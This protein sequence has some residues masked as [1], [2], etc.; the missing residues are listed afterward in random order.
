MFSA[1][2]VL[3][4]SFALRGHRSPNLNGSPHPPHNA[5][6]KRHTAL[7]LAALGRPGVRKVGKARR[8]KKRIVRAKNKTRSPFF[9]FFCWFHFCCL[10]RF[11]ATARRISAA[12]PC[13]TVRTRRHTVPAR[14]GRWFSLGANGCVFL[15]SRPPLVGRRRLSA[16]PDCCH[17]GP[18]SHCINTRCVAELRRGASAALH[19]CG[20]K[21]IFVVRLPVSWELGLGLFRVVR[22]GH[23]G[24]TRPHPQ[25]ALPYSC[26]GHRGRGAAASDCCPIWFLPF[27]GL[28]T[29]LLK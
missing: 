9:V 15:A 1:F 3:F 28:C 5:N 13:Q 19:C 4:M 10:L 6:P 20:L 17:D 7:A 24:F 25:M 27:P 2:L 16:T 11:F 8:M 18:L 23:L 22:R 29:S 21:G 14:V 12:M 26:A